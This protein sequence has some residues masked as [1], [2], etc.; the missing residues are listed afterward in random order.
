MMVIHVACIV[1]WELY[2]AVGKRIMA[3]F[4]TDEAKEPTI[5]TP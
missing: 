2:V 4:G 1:Q 5:I 3:L